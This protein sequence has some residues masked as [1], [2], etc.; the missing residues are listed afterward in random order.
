MPGG[1]FDAQDFDGEVARLKRD[2]AFLDAAHARRL[3]RL[4]GTR[5]RKLLGKAKSREDLGTLFG[6][7]LYEAEV[8][9]LAE[10]EWALTAEDVLWRRTKHGLRLSKE[11]AAALEKFM[12]G[13]SNH[14]HAAAE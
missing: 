1:D 6:A 5:A 8:R 12:R 7:D 3:V 2:Y 9:Y 4:Y 11:E 14:L 13:I 10:E